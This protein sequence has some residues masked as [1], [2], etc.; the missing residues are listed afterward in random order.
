MVTVDNPAFARV[1]LLLPGF[2]VYASEENLE[3]YRDILIPE[4]DR[5]FSSP[6]IK[7]VVQLGVL[8]HCLHSVPRRRRSLQ[9]LPILRRKVLPLS[10]NIDNEWTLEPWHIQTC[11]ERI[12][13]SVP[14]ECI[15]LPK[16]PISGP[17]MS[18]EGKEFLVY[19]TVRIRDDF[20]HK[21]IAREFWRTDYG[22]SRL[23]SAESRCELSIFYVPNLSREYF[24]GTDYGKRRIVLNHGVNSGYF[25]AQFIA[26]E[27]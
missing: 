15:K 12:M 25:C 27:F 11:L 8:Y 13:L 4:E 26:Q 1:D 17:N 19:I 10:M 9:L 3:K 20:V 6:Y 16:T 18:N 14:E 23:E 2:A 22:K 24:S 5:V 21:F 7:K